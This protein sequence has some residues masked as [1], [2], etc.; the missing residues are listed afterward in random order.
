ML[1]IISGLKY[2]TKAFNMKYFEAKSYK[3]LRTRKIIFISFTK[4]YIYK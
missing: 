3:I 2:V 4:I 1:N